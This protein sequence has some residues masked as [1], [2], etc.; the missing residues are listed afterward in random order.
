MAGDA[1]CCVLFQICIR[2]GHF[3]VAPSD[4]C[5]KKKIEVNK[6]E[7]LKPGLSPYRQGC[8]NYFVLFIELS[9]SFT[10]VR[11]PVIVH[12]HQTGAF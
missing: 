8:F 7:H 9:L 11:S 4:H 6:G 2:R 3:K 12:C 10:Y 5:V 1:K